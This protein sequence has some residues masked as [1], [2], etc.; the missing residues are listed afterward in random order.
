MPFVPVLWIV[1]LLATVGQQVWALG[2]PGLTAAAADGRLWLVRGAADGQTVQVFTRTRDQGPEVLTPVRRLNGRLTEGGAAASGQKLWLLFANGSVVTLQATSVPQ[3]R[4][5]VLFRTGTEASVPA[6][7]EPMSVAADAQGLWLLARVTDPSALD[8]LHRPQTPSTLPATQPDAAE[9]DLSSAAPQAQAE[10]DAVPPPDVVLLVLRRARWE[11]IDLPPSLVET[12]SSTGPR[13]SGGTK[14][15]PWDAVLVRTQEQEGPPLLVVGRRGG[16]DVVSVYHFEPDEDSGRWRAESHEVTTGHRVH[17]VEL[18]GQVAVGREHYS[19]SELTVELS[20]LRRGQTLAVGELKL[21]HEPSSA[22]WCL[23][24]DE[25]RIILVTAA[26]EVN[27]PSS[28]ADSAAAGRSAEPVARWTAMDLRGR[29]EPPPT[30]LREQPRPAPMADP[31]FIVLVG[32][33]VLASGLILLVFARRQPGQGP[34]KLAEGLMPAELVRRLAGGTI[35]LAPW[36]AAAMLSFGDFDPQGLF[37]QWPG[38]S[39]GWNA[40]SQGALAI[41]LYVVYCL[42]AELFIGRTLGKI[43]LGM[44]VTDM[45]GRRPRPW[46][47]VVRNVLKVPDLI[48]WPLLLLPVF[49]PIRQRLGDLVAGTVV[50]M[51]TSDSHKSD[52]GDEPDDRDD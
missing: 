31:D 17:A 21:P 50:L 45:D 49:I 48:A 23:T 4:T 41:G 42:V 29:I 39:G 10:A 25:Q 47:I 36:L 14:P 15:L 18:M 44:R 1:L 26:G 11:R 12:T 37:E 33:L 19:P 2:S 13:F 38:R 7:L 3:A 22:P 24:A 34:P 28:G 30:S 43:V 51:Q 6:G 9:A 5:S 20:L 46:Q 16:G 32:T 8:E 40:M 27:G 35:D 52:A